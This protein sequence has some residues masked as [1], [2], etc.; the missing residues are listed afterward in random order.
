MRLTLD[1]PPVWLAGSCAVAWGLGRLVPHGPGWQGLPGWVLILSGLS[2]MIA[3]A[4]TMWRKRTTLDPHGQPAALVTTGVFA[5]SR[6]PIYLGDA[7]ILVPV[8][9]I[10]ISRRFIAA[11]EARLATA[12]P[13]M[14]AQYRAH[15]RRWI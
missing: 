15:T 3:A 1:Y 2:V 12:F 14:F 8:F 11:E 9:M 5:L 10:V 4:G 13:D 6:N 7:L